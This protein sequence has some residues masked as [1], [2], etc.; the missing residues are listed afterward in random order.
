MT[1]R[2]VRMRTIEAL[3]TMGVRSSQDLVRHAEPTVAYIMA[4]DDKVAT[5]RK[6]AAKKVKDEDS[7]P[8][9][10]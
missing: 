3:S 6:P 8:T 2:E 9:Q 7:E 10:E 4:G 1:E 5:P